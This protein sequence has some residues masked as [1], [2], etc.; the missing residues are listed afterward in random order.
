[1]KAFLNPPPMTIDQAMLAPDPVNE[2]LLRLVKPI[3]AMTTPEYMF[4]R[5]CTSLATP[6]MVAFIR[7]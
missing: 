6:T 5:S 2:V 4:Y 3:E 7:P 1:M